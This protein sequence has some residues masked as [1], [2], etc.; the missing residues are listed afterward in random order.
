M[1]LEIVAITWQETMDVRQ[2]VLW[3]DQ[4]VAFCHVEGDE[5]A[6][7]FGAYDTGRLIGV[8][9][10]YSGGDSVRLRKLAVIESHQGRGVGSTLLRHLLM[11]A[12]EKGITEFWCDARETA[13]DFYR[14]F[15]LMPE[16]ER[17][18][19]ADVAYFKMSRLI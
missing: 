9:S 4:P 3:P 14:Q 7:H 1:E 2:Q 12:K 10:L 5:V 16:G 17:F 13:I 18:Y 11:I 15:G 19:K 6:W 8:A